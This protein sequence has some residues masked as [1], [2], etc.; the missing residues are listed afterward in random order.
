M[1]WGACRG[2][3]RGEGASSQAGEL[4]TRQQQCGVGIQGVQLDRN[5]SMSR[6]AG[7]RA[8]AGIECL[9]YAGGCSAGMHPKHIDTRAM[10][11]PRIVN[12]RDANWVAK[13]RR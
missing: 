4:E 11:K 1:M 6:G 3:R 5:G 8:V 13:L 7:N 10:Q 12:W 2:A 9:W